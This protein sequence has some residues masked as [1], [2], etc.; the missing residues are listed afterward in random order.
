MCDIEITKLDQKTELRKKEELLR[1]RALAVAEAA[2]GLAKLQHKETRTKLNKLFR[3]EQ[4]ESNAVEVFHPDK[5][6]SNRD[7]FFWYY[8][9]VRLFPRGDCAERCIQRSTHLPQWRWAKC[10]LSRAEFSL[11]RQDVEFVASL[12]NIFL[13]RDQVGAVEA[14]LQKAA[15]TDNDAEDLQK[16]AATGLVAQALSSGDVS[17][18]RDALRSK[19][20]QAPI[21][22]SFQMM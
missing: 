5:F 17:S 4:D 1:H 8:C 14:S 18:V 13:R 9:F 15:L 11:W 20:L 16:V 2:D 6:L 10:L 22:K 7:P 12:Y 19:N 3:R 21:Q